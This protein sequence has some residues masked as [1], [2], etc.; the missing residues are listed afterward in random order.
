MDMK[1]LSQRI[2]IGCVILTLLFI[3][4]NSMLPAD[5]SS[6]E[7]NWVQRLLEPALQF[8]RSGRI[9]VFVNGLADKLPERMRAAVYRFMELVSE[10]ILSQN[11]SFLVRKAAH[12]SEYM[13]LGFFMGLLWVR[14]DG[15]SRFFLPEGLCLAAAAIDE[16]IQ[17]F[18][19]GRSAQL[20]DVGVDLSGA[21]VGLLVALVLLA[22]LRLVIR[23]ELPPVG[24][25]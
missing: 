19:A 15:R 25:H 4:A 5:L 18:S 11:P 14:R 6:L 7:S 21:T 13:L 12:F 23:E 10:N 3:W 9:Q 22:V 20:R 16:S 2:L 24:K 17:L 1:R 8:I